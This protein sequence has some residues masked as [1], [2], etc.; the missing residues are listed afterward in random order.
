M[1][2]HFDWVLIE[3]CKRPAKRMESQVEGLVEQ[4]LDRVEKEVRQRRVK[5][6]DVEAPRITSFQ[7][8][9]TDWKM[10]FD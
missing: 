1:E 7:L 3:L 8:D 5:E 2:P 6:G 10:S 9:G 4:L